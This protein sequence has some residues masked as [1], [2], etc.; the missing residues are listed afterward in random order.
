M[1]VRKTVLTREVIVADEL[2]VPCPPVTRIAAMAVVANP[3]AGVDQEDLSAL[4]D[5]G[6]TLG[7]S[8]ATDILTVMDRAP[9]CYGKAV[10]VG[11][12]GVMEHGAAMLHPKLGKPVREAIRGGR[13]LMP[14]NVKV[15]AMGSSI[16]LPIGHKDEDWSFDHIDTMTLSVPD[17]PRADE[18]VLCLVLSD[19]TRRRARVGK[20]PLQTKD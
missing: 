13:A 1:R 3:F 10:I 7:G 19:G 20:G 11:A 14:S 5:I 12:A 6:A 18:I 16:D 9:V 8:L 2:G 15:A 4:F 17:A